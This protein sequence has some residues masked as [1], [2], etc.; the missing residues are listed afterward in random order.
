V[1]S[2]APSTDAQKYIDL[3]AEACQVLVSA[4]DYQLYLLGA[5]SGKADIEVYVKSK[6][7]SA[8][9]KDVQVL[10]DIIRK[11]LSEMIN[12]S[13]NDMY[14]YAAA[15]CQCMD[16]RICYA[17]VASD[18]LLAW[19]GSKM[20]LHSLIPIRTAQKPVVIASLNS[21]YRETKI[22]I[23][24]KFPVSGASMPGDSNGPSR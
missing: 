17:D 3:L 4:P 11:L 24:P 7:D 1:I 20:H 15:I 12:K 22:C 10:W 19:D 16:Q 8:L 23:A 2:V 5:A 21:N 18:P 13:Q 6:F 14:L 9:G